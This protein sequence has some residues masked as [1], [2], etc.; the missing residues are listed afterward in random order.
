[1][2]SYRYSIYAYFNPLYRKK[3]SVQYAL[4]QS[5]G[6]R[7]PISINDRFLLGST[8]TLT[9][10]RKKA[11]NYFTKNPELCIPVSAVYINDNFLDFD[12]TLKCEKNDSSLPFTLA[13]TTSPREVI[14][15]NSRSGDSLY[16]KSDGT[17]KLKNK[18]Y[19]GKIPRL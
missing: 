7:N 12:R 11:Y 10:A 16:I 17:S 18:A 3:Y 13:R 8:H 6:S 19:R 9:E 1:M 15:F 14:E 4:F 5:V 2:A